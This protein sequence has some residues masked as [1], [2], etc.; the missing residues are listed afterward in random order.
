MVETHTTFKGLKL[1]YEEMDMIF[2][3]ELGP[4]F[5][6]WISRL[7]I[8]HLTRNDDETVNITV[9]EETAKRLSFMR[10]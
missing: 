4:L 5:G 3:T 6:H 8:L 7:A 9:S 1:V 2:V 10:Q